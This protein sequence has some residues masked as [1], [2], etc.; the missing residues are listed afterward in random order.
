MATLRTIASR[1]TSLAGRIAAGFAALSLTVQPAAAQ[2]VLRDAETEALFRDISAP[3]IKAAGLEPRNVDIVLLNDGSINAFVAGGQAVYVH[4]GLI[5]AADHVSEVQG[6][7]AHELGHITGGHIIRN[8]EGARPATGIT[9]LSL[10]LGAAAAAAGAGEA[11]MGVFMAGQQAALGKYLAFSRAQ[12]SSADAAG[13][14][15][16]SKAGISGRGS[17]DFFKKLQNQEFRY[18]FTRN[19]DS[20]FYSSHPMTAD[21]LTTLQD[22]YEHDPAWNKPE[23][24][25]LQ[26]RFLRVKA[27]LYGYLAEPQATLNAYPEYL[28]DVPAHYARAYAYHKEAFMDKALAETQAILKQ[29]PNDPYALELEGQI[30]LESG[31]PADALE[32]LR[33]ATALTGNEPLIATTFGHALLATENKANFDEAEKILRT[34]IARDRENPFAWY[35]LGVVY[36]AKGDTARARLASAEQ[37]LMYLELPEAMRNAEAAEAALPKGSADWL[38]AQDI[39]YSARAMIERQGKKK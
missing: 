21:R 23:D 6:V 17:I 34:S 36:E 25:A 13:A 22:T 29:Q 9:I 11:A 31:H 15:F 35:Q 27:K 30:L 3:L 16:L 4:S 1:A 37:Q 18:G 2:S 8:D 7:I 24:P 10:L 32:P 19:A 39:A 14:Q 38:R 33:R 26:A 5:G 20:E 12:E 28:N